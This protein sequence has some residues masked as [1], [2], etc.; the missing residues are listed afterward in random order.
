MLDRPVRDPIE[1]PGEFY[2]ALIPLCE[3]VDIWHT[4]YQHLLPGPGAIVEWVKGTGLQP[5]VNAL[6]EGEVSGDLTTTA[7]RLAERLGGELRDEGGRPL[8]SLRA[9][10]PTAGGRA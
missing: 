9:S 4:V 2:D 10:A 6:P 8:D 7:R 1:T 3:R 5:F